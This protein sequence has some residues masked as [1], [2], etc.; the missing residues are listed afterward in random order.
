MTDVVRQLEEISSGIAAAM[1]EQS[2][3]TQE[4]SRNVGE[5][6]NGTDEVV[7]NISGVSAAAA[8]TGREAAVVLNEAQSLSER[9]KAMGESVQNFLAGIRA[10]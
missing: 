8:E 9:S 5:A 3:A 10:A 1:E 7:S 2:A 6:A 4:I